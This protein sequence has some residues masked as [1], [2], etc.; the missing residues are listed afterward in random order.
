MGAKPPTPPVF[1]GAQV[2]AVAA[3]GAP[4]RTVKLAADHIEAID[5]HGQVPSMFA[6]S[7]H[8]CAMVSSPPR[9]TCLAQFPYVVVRIACGMCASRQGSY[10]LAR[11]AEKYGSE[12][13]LDEVLARISADC[14]YQRG[15]HRPGDREPGQYVPRCHAYFADLDR[16]VPRPPD[17]PAALMRPRVIRGGKA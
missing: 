12:M 4:S 1:P 14:P 9:P 7:S 6:Q 11:L 8:R 3:S 13:P 15:P 10:R 16:P 5:A 17:L 2:G